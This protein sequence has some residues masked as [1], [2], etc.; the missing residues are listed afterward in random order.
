LVKS[1]IMNEM[2]TLPETT[3]FGARVHN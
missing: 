3:S 1:N 2:S